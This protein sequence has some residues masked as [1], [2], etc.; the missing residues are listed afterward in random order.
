MKHLLAMTMLLAAL[1]AP[2]RAT[3]G[4]CEDLRVLIASLRQPPQAAAPRYALFQHCRRNVG[5][6]IDERL[7]TWRPASPAPVVESLAAEAMRCLPGARR[8]DDPAGAARGEA[9][10]TFELLWIIIGQDGP[11]SGAP[12]GIVRL[13]VSVPEG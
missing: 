12:G 4:F 11:A 2:A 3:P 8:D 1:P 9:R 10:L 7:C 6:F 5:G 13:V